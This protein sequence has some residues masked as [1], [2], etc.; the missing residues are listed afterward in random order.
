MNRYNNRREKMVKFMKKCN[1]Y[2]TLYIFQNNEE[3]LLEHLKD[4]DECRKEYEE[5]KKLDAL[6]TEV[7]PYFKKNNSFFKLKSIAVLFIIFLCFF[8]FGNLSVNKIALNQQGYDSLKN[9]PSI[10]ELKGLPTDEY[11]LLEI[12]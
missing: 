10:V 3:A 12:E 8:A 7:K 9:E 11:G 6:L 2:E 4:C 5:D 1:K